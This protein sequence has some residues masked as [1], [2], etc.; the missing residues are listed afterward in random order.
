MSFFLV[1]APT[2]KKNC[3]PGTKVTSFFFLSV[4]FFGCLIWSCIFKMHV[5]Y[6]NLKSMKM[7]IQNTDNWSRYISRLMKLNLQRFINKIFILLCLCSPLISSYSS[8]HIPCASDTECPKI[9]RK[10]VLHLLKYTANLY[11][12]RCSTDLR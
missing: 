7:R 5:F 3:C 8:T 9:Y 11:L 10:Y 4:S 12:I 6:S 2:C 1:F